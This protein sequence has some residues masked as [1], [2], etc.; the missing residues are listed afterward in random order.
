MMIEV[1]RLTLK[2]DGRSFATDQQLTMATRRYLRA[3][4]SVVN[5]QGGLFDLTFE[6]TFNETDDPEEE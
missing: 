4:A 6:Q 2:A 3:L 1:A 5:L